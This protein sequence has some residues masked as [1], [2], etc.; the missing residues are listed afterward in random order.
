[1][2]PTIWDGDKR[3]DGEDEAVLKKL[4][5]TSV[6]F[7]ALDSV[8]IDLQTQ[9]P[10]FLSGVESLEAIIYPYINEKYISA[11]ESI[12][13]N[14]KTDVINTLGKSRTEKMYVEKNARWT[15][16]IEKF[17]AISQLLY[18]IE[19]YPMT[20]KAFRR[21]KD[22]LAEEV[23]R[24]IYKKNRHALIVI[25]GGTG[26]GKSYVALK[27]AS[28]I[29]K[30]FNADTLE[31]RLIFKPEA[32]G[33]AIANEKLK[34]GN[35]IILDEAGVGLGARDFQTISNKVISKIIQ[36]MRF[37]NLC[38]I[39]TV[40]NLEWIDAIARRSVHYHIRTKVIDL[41]AK[42][43]MVKVV[44]L[45]YITG[46]PRPY[47]FFIRGKD[48]KKRDPIWYDLIEDK[49]TLA[50]Y[51]ELA[52]KFKLGVASSG[53]KRITSFTEEKTLSPEEMRLRTV[54]NMVKRIKPDWDK[55]KSV[56]GGKES[57]TTAT[58]MN[59]YG[60]SLHMGRQIKQLLEK[61]K[62]GQSSTPNI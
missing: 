23:K 28:N 39:M 44:R 6:I 16:A 59:N 15:L 49:N 12:K 51:E 20:K 40:P 14:Y 53:A 25:T 35:A 2:T 11:I 62:V 8:R 41:E 34:K 10:A 38:V 4:D 27:I 61:E 24:L 45:K 30:T 57:V 36:T 22:P 52:R 48:G 1:M 9:N 47:E 33:R 21:G 37:R 31:E 13:Y 55:I 7:R 46:K 26:T 43:T 17:K 29:D 60:V 5:L 56:R 50:K 18:D 58:L 32:F 19:F 54:R 42:S 3:K